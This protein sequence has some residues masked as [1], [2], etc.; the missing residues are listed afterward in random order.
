MTILINGHSADRIGNEPTHVEN[1]S[2]H[3]SSTL[4]ENVA[5]ASFETPV[6]NRA[7]TH[8][9][10]TFLFSDIGAKAGDV[11][12]AMANQIPMCFREVHEIWKH[13]ISMALT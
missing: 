13:W 3:A 8:F 1:A 11:I 7:Q 9:Q 4:V 10:Q 5:G 12:Y 2:S 6:E